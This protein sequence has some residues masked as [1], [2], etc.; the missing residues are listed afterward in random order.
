MELATFHFFFQGLFRRKG[1]QKSDL[2]I[3]WL[4]NSFGSDR[5]RCLYWPLG[6]FIFLSCA[7]S[8]LDYVHFIG[9]LF[10]YPLAHRFA[11]G[12]V[13]GLHSLYFG[14]EL[15]YCLAGVT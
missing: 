12:R 11:S 14:V 9:D 7:L 6:G 13:V 15:L 3:F 2:T 10:Q 4:L 8:Q 1:K 5:A